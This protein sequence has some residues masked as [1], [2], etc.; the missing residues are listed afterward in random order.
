MQKDAQRLEEWSVSAQRL[1]QAAVVRLPIPG[2]IPSETRK[3]PLDERTTRP[4]SRRGW[5][6][7]LAALVTLAPAAAPAQPAMSPA[8]P[9]RPSS[10]AEPG[11]KPVSLQEAIQIAL[12]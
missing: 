3:L 11:A 9:A 1:E 10:P 6:S 8:A 5:L 4:E 2:R 7:C 12:Q